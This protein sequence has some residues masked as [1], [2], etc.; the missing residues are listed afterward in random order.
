MTDTQINIKNESFVAYI[1]GF[2]VTSLA[3]FY[4]LVTG[5]PVVVTATGVIEG[6][7][8][9]PLYMIPVF[10]PYGILI[11]ELFYSWTG[12]ENKRLL[13]LQFIEIIT[14]GGVSFVRYVTG[15]PISGHGIILAFFLLHQTFTKKNK[16]YFRI[17]IGITVLIITIT[18]KIVFWNDPITL[19]LGVIVGIVLWLPGYFYR[20]K[21]RS[22]RIVT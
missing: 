4:F 5:F 13:I 8:T 7:I 20:I 16:L 17:I 1:T 18:F 3:I 15:I 6:V 9:P 19:L 11:G 22:R 21:M 10:F 2:I 12:N 14:V